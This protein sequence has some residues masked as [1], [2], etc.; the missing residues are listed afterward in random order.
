VALGG[1]SPRV[2][3]GQG[4]RVDGWVIEHASDRRPQITIDVEELT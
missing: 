2:E 3:I 1:R 4:Q